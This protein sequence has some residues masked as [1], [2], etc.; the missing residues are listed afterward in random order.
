MSTI[1]KEFDF[2]SIPKHKHRHDLV[3]MFWIIRSFPLNLSGCS[4]NGKRTMPSVLHKLW[5]VLACF[6]FMSWNLLCFTEFT[7]LSPFGL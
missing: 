3:L 1:A 2:Q 6:E 5:V 7:E 4:K